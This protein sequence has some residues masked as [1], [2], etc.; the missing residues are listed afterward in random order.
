MLEIR[1][2]GTTWPSGRCP[3]TKSAKKTLSANQCQ[4]T[5]VSKQLLAAGEHASLRGGSAFPSATEAGPA[6]R[7]VRAGAAR[8]PRAAANQRGAAASLRGRSEPMSAASAVRRK[9]GLGARAA[10]WLPAP[11]AR[12]R[13]RWRRWVRAGGTRVRERGVRAARGFL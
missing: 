10:P 11:R 8:A 13:R 2:D 12:W 9:A 3:L 6:S 7:S 1:L 4:Q 5:N